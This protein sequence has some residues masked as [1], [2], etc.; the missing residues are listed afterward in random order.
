LTVRRA[1][2]HNAAPAELSMHI[3][4]RV[5]LILAFGLTAAGCSKCGDWYFGSTQH[6]CHDDSTIK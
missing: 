3:A 5:L 6:S 1:A 2:E 4:V